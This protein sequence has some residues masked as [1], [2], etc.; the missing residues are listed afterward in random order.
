MTNARQGG[1][2]S[3]QLAWADRFRGA[4]LGGAVGDALGS[5]VR[6]LAG[7]QI[8]SWF[9]PRGLVDFVPVYGRPGAA[10]EVTQL[11]AF[12]LDG[13]LRAKAANPDGTTFLPTGHVLCNYQRW[14]RTQGV[15]WEYAMSAHLRAEPAPTGWLLERSEL[16]STRNPAGPQ[17][18]MIGQLPAHTSIGPDGTLYPLSDVDGIV[19]FAV[20]AAPAMVWSH[21]PEGVYAT[22]AGIANAFTSAPNSV[23]AAGLHS[24][25]LAQLTRGVPLW[26]AVR[27]AERQRLGAAYQVPGVPAD[28]RRAVHAAMFVGQRGAPLTPA[29]VD[30]EFDVRGKPGELGIALAAVGCTNNFA[31]AVRMAVNHSADSAVTGAM[32]GQLAG[33]VHGVQAVPAHWL[34]RL[35]LREVIEILCQDAAEAF[36][37]PS[38]ARR[39]MPAQDG[40]RALDPVST[41]D[42]SAERTMVLPA[43]TD[44]PESTSDSQDLGPR[45]TA[46]REIGGPT[47]PTPTAAETTGP[48]PPAEP[49]APRESRVAPERPLSAITPPAEPATR[50]EPLTA[51]EPIGLPDPGPE[52]SSAPEP[53]VEPVTEPEPISMPEPAAEPEPST[54]PEPVSAEEPVSAPEEAPEPLLPPLRAEPAATGDAPEE[55]TPADDREVGAEPVPDADDESDPAFPE[56]EVTTARAE[57][58]PDRDPVDLAPPAR[59]PIDL[60][61]EGDDRF[62]GDPL[63]EPAEAACESAA[64]VVESADAAVAEPD[65]SASASVPADVVEDDGPTPIIR[66]GH[67][68]EEG[69]EHGAPSLT[70]RVLGCFL[71]GALGDAFGAD[72]EFV[73]AEEITRR[74]GPDG[75]DGLREAYGVHG[76]ITDDTQMTLFTAEGL[77]RGSIARRRFG[78]EDPL[79]EVQLAYQRWLHTQ[80]VEWE[81]AAGAFR[82]GHPV[83]DGWLVEVPGLFRTRAP[84]KT[85]FRA[86]AR[87]GDGHPAGSFTEKINDSKGCGGA[88]RAAPAALYSTDPAEVFRLA[89]RTA[90]LTHSHPAGY[91]SAGA[92]AVIVQQALL[93]RGLDDGVWLALQVLETWD[94]HEETSA[95]L[96]SAVDLAARGVPTPQQVAETLG[97]GWVGEQALAIAVCAALAAGEDVE[98]ALRIAVHHSGDSDS[99]GAI[100]GNIVGALHGVGALPVAWLADLELRD[101]VEQIALDC[102]AEFGHG[103]FLPGWSA[104][105]PVDE[106]W[107]ERYP[108]RP[109][110]SS[111]PEVGV[112]APAAPPAEPEP[113]PV[114]EF[115]APKP[116][117]RRINGVPRSDASEDVGAED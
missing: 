50:S 13:L 10:T 18:A 39:Y 84:G 101:V 23:A 35:E 91:H 62:P 32:A 97:G 22:A 3:P 113:D 44:A 116:A 6:N 81:S 68:K 40:V 86:L 85:V 47:L 114:A 111:E 87:F 56:A 31:D 12:T 90:A 104:E 63:P 57:P 1:P 60:E 99:T 105:Q 107:N 100:C 80:G 11:T 69:P 71:G 108:V 17:L 88:M 26:D 78:V 9:G 109:L 16:H 112:A 89:A 94:D 4:M 70:E 51:P 36:A 25:V 59:E 74:F 93:G 15:P 66:G 27:T 110:W 55:D 5:G 95:M 28:V 77:I 20:W 8:H 65:G 67:A 115:P 58:L 92:L 43:I 106:D 41:V 103:A 21:H 49:A 54:E 72:L 102:V 52:P 96:K 42:G 34:D 14:L 2:G 117:P 79:P 45:G 73:T 61:P 48:I 29:D 83:P 24:D 53:V 82:A 76:A 64:F 19:D 75:P 98:L 7:P 37:P 30:V 46:E 38:W 33:A